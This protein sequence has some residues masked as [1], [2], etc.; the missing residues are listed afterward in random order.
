[1]S[2]ALAAHLRRSLRLL[3]WTSAEKGEALVFWG[4]E[5]LGTWES[6]RPCWRISPQGIEFR[7]SAGSRGIITGGISVMP[8]RRG[9]KIMLRLPHR[10]IPEELRVIWDEQDQEGERLP[11]SDF[12]GAARR[13]IAKE[14]PGSLI[15]SASNRCDRSHSI[16]GSYLRIH[17]RHHG[18]D[19]LMIAL[20][21]EAGELASSMLTQGLLWFDWLRRRGKLSVP[22]SICL[23]VPEGLTVVLYHRSRYLNMER[24]AVEIWE[25]REQEGRDWE[26][27]RAGPAPPP[28]ENRDFKWPLLGP[29][30]WSPLLAR[31][32]DL[33]PDSIRRYPRLKEFDSLRILGLEF[34]RVTGAQRDRICFGVGLQH[35]EL[36]EENFD[37][38]RSLVNQI[39]YFRRADSPDVRHPYYRIQSERW[40]ESMILDDSSRLF[41]ELASEAV[42]SQ[43]PVY[44]GRDPGRVD[45][46]GIDGEGTLVVMELKVSENP[47][48]PLQSLDYWGRVVLHN[49]RGDFERRGYFIRN[50]L[51]RH[52]P[53]IYLVSP[54]FSF[55]DSTERILRFLDPHLEV[56]KISINED[57]RSGVR[58]LGQ[59]RLRCGDLP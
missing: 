18:K 40:L 45:I 4:S 20:P 3:E 46:L 26:V 35:V 49:L 30:R 53:K 22:A 2:R 38:L 15:L 16:S 48:L 47:D 21:S 6:I 10:I 42:Y 55:H 14:K 37:N 56:W 28:E 31:V 29:F 13:W 59:K 34:A 5:K 57:W 9:A 11:A 7:F 52:T 41:P 8:T 25:Y 43:I 50:R 24:V 1:M 51:S 12:L 27:R 32:L 54:V 58:V 44:L 17:F 19:H 36:Q 33:A 23:L 39:L